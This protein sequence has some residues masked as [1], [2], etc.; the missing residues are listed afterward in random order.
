M[1]VVVE[2]DE[3]EISGVIEDLAVERDEVEISGIIDDVTV[4]RDKV[5][6]TGITDDLAIFV[7][8]V[9][10]MDAERLEVRV[11]IKLV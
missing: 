9:V 10:A 4:E 2:R 7:L 5:E 1:A 8:T 3:V 11:D 6:I